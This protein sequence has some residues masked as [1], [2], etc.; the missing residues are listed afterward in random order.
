MWSRQKRAPSAAAEALP[1][2][3]PAALPR[4]VDPP[5]VPEHQTRVQ[6]ESTLAGY[7]AWAHGGLALAGAGAG[8]SRRL[9]CPERT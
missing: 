6:G 8:P 5:I 4:Y 7:Q 2:R 3:A 1:M 9:G